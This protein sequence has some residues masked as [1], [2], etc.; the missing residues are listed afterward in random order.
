MYIVSHWCDRK[1]KKQQQQ[2]IA[3]LFSFHLEGQGGGWGGGWVGIS[4]PR[5][6]SRAFDTH[7]VSY[8][9]IA[10]QR[11]LLEKRQIASSVKDRWF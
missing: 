6:Y 11:I 8:Q 3:N 9:N 5:G 4:Q 2:T 1:K 7:A 10:T